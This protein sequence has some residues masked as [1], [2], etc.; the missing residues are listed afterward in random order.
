MLQQIILAVVISKIAK[1][2]WPNAITVWGGPRVSGLGC[3]T[4]E[5]D[6]MERSF[7][8]DIIVVGRAEQTFVQILDK[9]ASTKWKKP[10]I[11]MVLSGQR[12]RI[13]VAPTFEKL[14]FYDSPLTPPAQSALG[15]LYGR[16]AYCIYPKIEPKPEKLNLLNAVGSVADMAI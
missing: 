10:N 11:P 3:K 6:L 1:A 13:S 2:I 14:D 4:I 15:G 5:K 7:A 8:A 12:G 16:R 9:V